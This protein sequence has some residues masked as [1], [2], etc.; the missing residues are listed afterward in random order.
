MGYP[1]YALDVCV[2]LKQRGFRAGVTGAHEPRGDDPRAS[3]GKSEVGSSEGVGS[4]G[5]G[6]GDG[7]DGGEASWAGTGLLRDE[8][9]TEAT[10]VQKSRMI[11]EK[12]GQG[13]KAQER[14]GIPQDIKAKEFIHELPSTYTTRD[15]AL[16]PSNP[17]TSIQ[18]H[19]ALDQHQSAVTSVTSRTINLDQPGH[20]LIWALLG[21]LRQPAQQLV[22]GCDA[23]HVAVLLVGV[24]QGLKCNTRPSWTYSG[25]IDERQ[26]VKAERTSVIDAEVMK[27]GLR[28][29]IRGMLSVVHSVGNPWVTRPLPTPIPTKNPYPGSWVWV[30]AVAG[31]G[32]SG[33]RGYGNPC[34]LALRSLVSASESA[35]SISG[36][37][38]QGLG[39]MGVEYR[40]VART[41]SQ[42]RELSRVQVQRGR[43]QKRGWSITGGR[44][45]LRMLARNMKLRTC[46]RLDRGRVAVE[47]LRPR[48]S[49]ATSGEG[50][51]VLKY[52][53]WITIQ[54][55]K[56]YHPSSCTRHCALHLRAA[57]ATR[58]QRVPD[59]GGHLS[60]PAKPRCGY[61]FSTGTSYQ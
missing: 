11:E 1:H 46:D 14:E 10:A 25:W 21:K 52:W 19:K 17:N 49:A 33:S 56:N 43:E 47:G 13:A 31:M 41:P 55:L 32:T 20:K 9:Q 4:N 26:R 42:G 53:G 50:T 7:L 18:W 6:D 15:G 30:P 40:K 24:S 2:S 44:K 34:R 59:H 39:V 60:K 48:A 12:L 22:L 38:A 37:F 28:Q 58:P 16:K 27:G 36:S 8:G 57:L 45:Q 5:D 29:G 3:E 23:V 54:W 35:P 51:G 61:G